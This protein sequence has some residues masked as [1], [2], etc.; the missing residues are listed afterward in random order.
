VL[1]IPGRR[2]PSST[3]IPSG[4]TTLASVSSLS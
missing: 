3:A 1:G 2:S 4:S